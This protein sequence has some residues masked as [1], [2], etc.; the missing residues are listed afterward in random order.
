ME[1]IS[2]KDLEKLHSV[3]LEMLLDIDKFCKENN[4][5]YFLCGGTLLGAIRHKG[6]IPWDDDM[7]IGMPRSDYEKFIKLYPQTNKSK[8][9]VECMENNKDYFHPYAKVRKSNTLVLERFIKGI[10]DRNEIFVD[11]FP[12]DNATSSYKKIRIRA[13]IIKAIVETFYVKDHMYKLGSC[14]HKI[15]SA[16]FLPFKKTTLYKFQ[17]F[18]MTKYNKKETGYMVCFVGGYNTERELMEKKV[19]LPVK[20][21][22]FC[23][24]K[25]NIINNP[26][27][28][29]TRL[30]GDYLTLP[31]IDKRVNHNILEISFN[32]TKDKGD[33]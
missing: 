31:P 33:L 16:L 17:K 6:F 27:F 32:T 22:E 29:L 7:D 20:K 25:V 1:S 13:N 12:F 10:K 21:G 26:D 11:V 8:Y 4:L 28:Y 5:T 30:Y 3:L 23:L 18:L 2:D 24:K 19:F 15:F 9:Y 14:Y